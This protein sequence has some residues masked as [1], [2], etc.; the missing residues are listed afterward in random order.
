MSTRRELRAKAFGQNLARSPVVRDLTV[1]Q[2]TEVIHAY[3]E[4][5][6]S[7]GKAQRLYTQIVRDAFTGWK[8][9]HDG[10]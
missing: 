2:I 8:Q 7:D 9:M 1:G 5:Q 10:L 6:T 4:A 3:V